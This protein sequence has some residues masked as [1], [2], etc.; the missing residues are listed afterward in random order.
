[1]LALEAQ[2]WL[3]MCA[4]QQL[5]MLISTSPCQVFSDTML[6]PGCLFA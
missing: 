5:T 6:A 3:T 4:T 2:V 1:M